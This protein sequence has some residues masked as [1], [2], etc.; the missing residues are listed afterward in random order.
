MAQS[1]EVSKTSEDSRDPDLSR[2]TIL[3]RW[4]R[5]S[6]P[7]TRA[8]ILDRYAFDPA[9]LDAALGRL[10]ADVRSSRATS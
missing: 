7:V 4:L 5:W 8:A 2:R 6:G 9:W 1:S 3:T 10:L